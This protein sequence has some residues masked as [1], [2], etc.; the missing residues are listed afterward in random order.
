MRFQVFL[1]PFRMAPI[2]SAMPTM[3]IADNIMKLTIS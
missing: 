2:I 1:I 3:A